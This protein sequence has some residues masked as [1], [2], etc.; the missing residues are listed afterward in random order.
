MKQ[1]GLFNK[2]LA[3]VVN[4]NSTRLDQLDESAQAIEKF[5]R[6]SSWD[7]SILSFEEQGSWAHQTII[8][9][10]SGDPFDADLIV[11]VRPVDGWSAGDYINKLKGV[12]R[13]SDI[14]KDKVTSFSHCVTINYA[15]QRKI[16]IAPVVVNR[17]GTTREEVCNRATDEFELTAPNA[18]TAW[19][20]KHNGYSGSNSFRKVT[21]LIKYLRDIKTT[22]TCPSILLTT[23][24]GSQISWL[25]K[26]SSAFDDVPTALQTIMGRL[27]DF[28]QENETKPC[29]PNPALPEDE[30]FA[31]LWTDEQYT[32]FRN[33]IHKYRDWIDEAIDETDTAKSIKAW[34]RVF[35]AEFGKS[36]T[37]A[38][39]KSLNETAVTA[40][41]LMDSAARHSN[42]LVDL[43]ID[44]G[45]SILPP[46]FNR[47]PHMQSPKWQPASEGVGK[48]YVHAQYQAHRHAQ[49]ARRVESGDTLPAHGGIWLDAALYAGTP[50]PAGARVEWR[51]T[52]TGV[53]ALVKNQGRGEFNLPHSGNRRWEQLQYRG[54]HIAEA[55]IIRRSDERLIAQSDPFHVVIT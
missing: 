8:K 6:N 53:V 50:I 51:I 10:L 31:D 5:I 36:V 16:D 1:P 27:D 34:Q 46:F 44:F 43:V 54:V 29:I 42:R 15:G 24:L 9:P 22:F 25:D 39:A 18:Y 14:Y 33:F 20:I 21:R 4:L 49:V 13:G 41:A 37:V 19:L 23:L 30:D 28:L 45:T 2:F 40:Q 7:A 3:D 55:F 47:P 17:G 48:A 38:L 32:N 12:F 11:R 26:G 52:N 35:G